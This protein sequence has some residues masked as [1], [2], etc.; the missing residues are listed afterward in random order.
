MKVQQKHLQQIIERDT[1]GAEAVAGRLGISIESLQR[2]LFP[3]EHEQHLVLPYVYWIKAQMTQQEF[4]RSAIA[5]LEMTRAE[6]ANRIS[7]PIKTLNKWMLPPTSGTVMADNMWRFI[8][9]VVG[10]M[11]TGKNGP[12]SSP[13]FDK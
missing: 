6:F 10:T 7:T 1:G 4:L 3:V 11:A 12:D 2:Y 5:S 13:N 9:E 8:S